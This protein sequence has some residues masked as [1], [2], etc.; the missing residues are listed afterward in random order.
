M[1]GKSDPRML[2]HTVLLELP[3]LFSG[4]WGAQSLP[5]SEDLPQP[6]QLLQD[7]EESQTHN[8]SQ[9][10]PTLHRACR[11]QL[12]ALGLGQSP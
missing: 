1:F 4:G 12:P 10:I 2:T 3:A 7:G 11:F 6:S 5:P 9:G 8:G